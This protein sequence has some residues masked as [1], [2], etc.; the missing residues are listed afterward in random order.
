MKKSI[1]LIVSTLIISI[2][3][4]CNTGSP[5]T[6]NKD[7]ST[8]ETTQVYY[9]CTMHPEIHSDKPGKCPICGMD[10]VKV[11]STIPDPLMTK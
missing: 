7:L 10:L 4:A 2:A 11:E 3:F 6:S 9:T 8:Q 5:K 1:I